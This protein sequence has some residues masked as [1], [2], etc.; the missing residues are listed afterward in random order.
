MD[1][2]KHLLLAL[3]DGE[4]LES[5]WNRNGFASLEEAAGAIRRAASRLDDAVVGVI[6]EGSGFS[7]SGIG[8]VIIHVDGA[9]RGNPG[10]AA[11]AAVAFTPEGEQL[12]SVARRIGKA[13]NNVAEYTALIEGLRLACELGVQEAVF[14]LDSELVVKQM[15]GEYRIKNRELARLA[16]I[17]TAEA[18]RFKRCLFEKVP[19]QENKEADR[20]ANRALDGG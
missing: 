14:R 4:C 8:C 1:K 9:S 5:A 2:L 11:V 19:R 18:S 3:A 7:R 12:T 17:V 20:L 10:P 6:R 15:N 13:T 16:R